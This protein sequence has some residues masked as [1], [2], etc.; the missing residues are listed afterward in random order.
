MKYLVHGQ[1]MTRNTATYFHNVVIDFCLKRVAHHSAFCNNQPV[2]IN[3]EILYDRAA[4]AI[5][6]SIPFHCCFVKI[7]YF[8]R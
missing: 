1:F 7:S 8:A 4:I 5:I 2:T 6:T 3:Q